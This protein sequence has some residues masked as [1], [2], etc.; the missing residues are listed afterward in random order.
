MLQVSENV[1][2]NRDQ[3]KQLAHM[4]ETKLAQMILN[5]QEMGGKGLHEIIEGGSADPSFINDTT[6]LR[7]SVLSYG[8]K[9]GLP[10]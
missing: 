1:G 2:L 6:E 3:T 8:R 10:I 9:R 4:V 7:D 5:K